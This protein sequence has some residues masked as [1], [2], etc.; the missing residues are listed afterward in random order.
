MKKTK[1]YGFTIVELVIVIAVIAILSAVLIPTLGG[2]IEDAQN[3]SRDTKAKN[4]YTNYITYHPTEDNS[5]LFIEIEDG[6]ATYYYSVN[7]GQIDLD[8]E[9]ESLTILHENGIHGNGYVVYPTN[10]NE[11][12]LEKWYALVVNGTKEVN[13]ASII[14]SN[15]FASNSAAPLKT[16]EIA[17]EDIDDFV[18]YF[19][20]ISFEEASCYDEDYKTAGN[21]QI[22]LVNVEDYD[23]DSNGAKQYYYTYFTVSK[24]GYVFAITKNLT[25][26]SPNEL[27]FTHSYSGTILKSETTIDRAVIDGY[28]NNHAE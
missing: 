17:N 9:G 6:G 14:Y 21:C 28:F 11:L 2:V 20:N 18:E 16:K 22:L 1:N 24:N 26:E 8:N 7:D 13:S 4:A 25:F 23:S 27:L 5:Y 3:T 12:W 10:A 19:R 15:M